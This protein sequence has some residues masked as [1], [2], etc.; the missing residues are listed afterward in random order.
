MIH[1]RSVGPKGKPEA[2]AKGFPFN[3]PVVRS[4]PDLEFRSPVTF[5]VGE[6]GSG[7]STLLEAIAAGI[8]SIVVGGE[9]IQSDP[10]LAHARALA[11]RLRLVWSK[12]TRKGFFL[13]AEDVF[14]FVR[15]VNATAR[16]LETIA[17]GFSET[18]SGDG[19]ARAR[20]SVLAQRAQLARRYGEDADARSHGE[21]FLNLFQQRIVPGGLYLLDE[22]EAA[23]SPLRQL[24]L[25][26][27]MK[28]TVADDGQFL[29]ATHSPLLMA[30]PGAMILSF[31]ETPVREVAYDDTEH[32]SLT[33]AFLNDP[34]SFLRRL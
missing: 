27:L 16:D 17:D 14:N 12:R 18:M 2:S 34:A 20:G 9:D 19:L 28:E 32:V 21:T 13:R 15:R 30:F 26:S 29:I 25:L 33:R 8:G 4:L 31:D 11:A 3:L 23:L 22:P 24:S 7:K 6:N 1:L 10:S 5:L